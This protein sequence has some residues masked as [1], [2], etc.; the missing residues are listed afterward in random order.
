MFRPWVLPQWPQ[1]AAKVQEEA[2]QVMKMAKPP[3]CPPLPVLVP[4]RP[5][6][7]AALEDPCPS[8]QNPWCHIHIF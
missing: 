2:G 7:G 5:F 1:A 3:P 4:Q 8:A 6:P